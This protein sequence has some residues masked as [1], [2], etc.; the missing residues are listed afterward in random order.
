MPHLSWALWRHYD[1]TFKK[2][3]SNT[4]MSQSLA[5]SGQ[6]GTWKRS[7]SLF[8]IPTSIFRRFDFKNF[9]YSRCETHFQTN[10]LYFILAMITKKENK[11]IV[12]QKRKQWIQYQYLCLD[13]TDLRN[14]IF[15]WDF[16]LSR[17]HLQSG[18]NPNLDSKVSSFLFYNLLLELRT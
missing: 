16:Q 3:S 18:S 12:I 5:I 7:I 4:Y 14:L 11:P 9:N 1:K 6:N 15:F 2:R 13:H 17:C 10:R 8:D